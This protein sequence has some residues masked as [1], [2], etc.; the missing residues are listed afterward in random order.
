MSSLKQLVSTCVFENAKRQRHCSR[1]K[2]HVILN[3]DKCFIVK[4]NMTK[5]SYCMA[6]AKEILLK[7]QNEINVL[8]NNY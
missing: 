5:K 2:E 8:L 4:E 3:G 6:C 7:A 1:N